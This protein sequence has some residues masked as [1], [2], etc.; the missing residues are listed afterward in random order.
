M[1]YYSPQ[2]LLDVGSEWVILGHSERRN[3]FNEDDKV[4]LSYQKPWSSLS[5]LICD[6]VVYAL[7]AGV[8]VI[9]CIGEQLS[10]REA[11]QTEEVVSRQLGALA[12]K[13]YLQ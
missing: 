7:S 11:G 4:S 8:K 3:I 12:R 2:M 5:Q 6:K 13:K 1:F 9:F 10:D